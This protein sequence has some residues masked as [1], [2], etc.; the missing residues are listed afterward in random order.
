MSD[1]TDYVESQSLQYWLNNVA[2]GIW[3]ALSTTPPNDD[4]TNFTE[5]AGGSYARATVSG[6]PRFTIGAASEG[7]T[8]G[9]NTEE[10]VFPA[11]TAPWGT[12]S[13]FGLFNNALSG[14]L[15]FKSVLSEAKII[16]TAD[17]PVF[18]GSELVVTNR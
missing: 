3:C 14:D 16:S 18:S 12:V 8:S 13:H 17:L 11:A 1:A 6:T 10:V 15:L 2:S 7:P 4:A 9:T 5:P